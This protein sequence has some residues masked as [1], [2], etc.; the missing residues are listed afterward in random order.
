MASYH[1]TDIQRNG[2]ARP[3]ALQLL[4][5][6]LNGKTV[7]Q[8][9]GEMGVPSERIEIRLNAATAY[10]LRLSARG[11]TSTT[12]SMRRRTLQR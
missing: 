1:L 8:L 11:G 9:S 2:S 3:V 7:E 5:E 12:L 10:L 6:Y 4:E